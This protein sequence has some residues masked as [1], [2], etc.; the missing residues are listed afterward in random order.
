MYSHG[1]EMEV[2]CGDSGRELERILER[3]IATR[4]SKQLKTSAICK[5]NLSNYEERLLPLS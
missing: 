3:N 4:V 1:G 5:N 2:A